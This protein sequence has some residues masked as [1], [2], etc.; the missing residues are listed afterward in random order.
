MSILPNQVDHDN[1]LLICRERRPTDD[2][3][4]TLDMVVRAYDVGAEL[5]SEWLERARSIMRQ[6]QMERVG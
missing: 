1:A 2:E 4:R 6:H 5:Q 3:R